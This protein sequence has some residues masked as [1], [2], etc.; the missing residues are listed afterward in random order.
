MSEEKMGLDQFIATM[1]EKG[2]EDDEVE[3]AKERER[4]NVRILAFG[5]DSRKGNIVSNVNG[6]ITFVDSKF[7]GKVEVNDVWI[8]ILSRHENVYYAMPVYKVN[9]SFLMTLYPDLKEEI[10]NTLWR[11]NKGAFEKD[12]AERYKNEVHDSALEEARNELESTINDLRGKVSYL[13]NQL[14]QN[15]ILSKTLAISQ[16]AV[17]DTIELGSDDAPACVELGSEPVRGQVQ[18]YVPERRSAPRIP[19]AVRSAAP[20]IPEIRVSEKKESHQ[21][22]IFSVERKSEETIY[23]ES[24]TEHKYFVHISPDT[25]MLVIRPSEFGSA[26]CINGSIRLNGLGKVS[27]F[28]EAKSLTSEYNERYEGLLVYL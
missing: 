16:V 18:E 2:L 27:P 22:L 25:K 4:K 9:A 24:F 11:R 23:S 21:H 19:V 13:E 26:L 6:T 17:P 8:C 3:E 5:L 10:I 15:R 28:T 12:F 1:R 14:E 20:G 7:P